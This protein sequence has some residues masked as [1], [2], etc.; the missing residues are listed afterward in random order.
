VLG[1]EVFVTV[2]T[3]ATP[4]LTVNTAV[5]HTVFVESH[6][7]YVT[8]QVLLAAGVVKLATPAPVMVAAGVQALAACGTPVTVKLEPAGY[9][10]FCATL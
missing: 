9:L 8:V 7:R 2:K 1:I 4:V 3:G 10:S 6:T 5:S